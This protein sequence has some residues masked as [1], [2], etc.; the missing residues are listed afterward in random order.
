MALD[1]RDSYRLSVERKALLRS[2]GGRELQV[3]DLSGSGISVVV[4]ESL[5]QE[6]RDR[7][8]ILHL[9]SAMLPVRLEIVRLLPGRD[10]GLFN[11][12]A[13]FVDLGLEGVRH[14]ATFLIDG[15]GERD[16]RIERL[17]SAEQMI[18]W[19]DAR[20]IKRLLYLHTI[21]RSV[22]FTP[23]LDAAPLPICLKCNGIDERGGLSATVEGADPRHL[24]RNRPLTFVLAGGES[25]FFFQSFPI[26]TSATGVVLSFPLELCQTGFRVSPRPRLPEETFFPVT[27]ES[28]Q[29]HQ[30][31]ERRLVDVGARGLSFQSDSNRELLLPGTRIRANVALSDGEV[32][33]DGIVRRVISSGSTSEYGL[34]VLEFA[35]QRSRRLW[36]EFVIKEA[37]PRLEFS[38]RRTAIK[39]W[40]ILTASEYT[41]LWTN[42]RH[43]RH[44]AHAFSD[45]WLAMPDRFG[46]VMVANDD[47]RSVGTA[48]ANLLYPKTWMVHHLGVDRQE[49][50]MKQRHEFRTLTRQLYAA[51]MYLIRHV[52]ET[53]Y[54][55][56]YVEEN[57]IWNQRIYR[58]FIDQYSA[59]RDSLYDS[60]HVYRG[61]PERMQED[62]A[63]FEIAEGD[64]TGIEALA[65]HLQD[66]LRP[67]EVDAFAY[68]P[69]AI[70]LTDFE[71]AC[72]AG[73]YERRRR[74]LFTKENGR[75]TAALIAELGS[76]GVN[77]FSLLNSCRFFDLGASPGAKKALLAAAGGMY[78]AA[79]KK[80]FV[81]FDEDPDVDESLASIGV[82]HVSPGVRWLVR[83]E[84][85][86][87]WL[88]YVDEMMRVSI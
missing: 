49:R 75:P 77:L 83:K 87:A 25:V 85:V 13:R 79:G 33:I 52:Y 18:R 50:T 61:E 84:V 4:P 8:S 21:S 31:V 19:R 22:P 17:L 43:R 80:S 30:N 7:P 73:G 69:N 40:H 23:Y 2:P 47:V 32:D 60:L 39:A 67:L 58:G 54:F 5:V 88:G 65:S 11:V 38:N 62:G 72:A 48:S 82:T 78:R 34:E 46:H 29:H 3:Q 53:K 44:L 12:G 36:H 51:A 86:P 6:L 1:R 55:V 24:E 66:N 37:N 28:P 59:Q 14:L 16:Q 27:F 70:G 42:R 71:T 45:A 26:E 68:Q 76:E 20:M 74:F 10:H 41:K 15:F 81:F 64:P 57:K 35:D 56:L 9:G 63:S